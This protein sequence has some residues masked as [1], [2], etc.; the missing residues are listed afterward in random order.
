MKYIVD[1]NTKVLFVKNNYLLLQNKKKTDKICIDEFFYKKLVN[2]FKNSYYFDEED[3]IFSNTEI[4][5]LTKYLIIKKMSKNMEKYIDTR[6][7]KYQIYLENI[8]EDAKQKDYISNNNNKKVLFIGAGG[9]CTAIL[10]YLISVGIINYLIIDFDNVDITNFNRQFKYNIKDIGK[11]KVDCLKNNLLAQYD[12]LQIETK[13]LK[14]KSI[15]DVKKLLNSYQPDFVV[16]AADTP[17]Y[18]IHKYIVNACLDNSTPCIFGGVGQ[19][20]GSFGPLLYNRVGMKAY[21]KEIDNILDSVEGVFPCK[22]SF[23]LTNSLVSNYI[24]RDIILYLMDKKKQIKSL[25]KLCVIDFDK[26]VIYEKR[27]YK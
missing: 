14:I 1:D 2:F 9:I 20:N 26:D 4:N 3:N 27:K 8:F 24:A 12:N 15:D 18:L 25:N 11:T 17:I 10:D 7:E 22:G 23:G 19:N 6:Y 21:L 5:F 13:N 16:C